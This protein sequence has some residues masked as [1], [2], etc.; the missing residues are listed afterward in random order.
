MGDVMSLSDDT[1][2]CMGHFAAAEYKSVLPPICI[3]YKRRT[4][5]MLAPYQGWMQGVVVDGK[6]EHKIFNSKEIA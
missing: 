6:C 5:K 3:G 4:A 2:R 1:A